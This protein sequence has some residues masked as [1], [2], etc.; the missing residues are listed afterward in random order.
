MPRFTICD[1]ST[2]SADHHSHRCPISLCII[3]KQISSGVRSEYEHSKCLTHNWS[4]YQDQSAQLALLKL[5]KLMSPID[6][7]PGVCGILT[8]TSIHRRDISQVEQ[9]GSYR[10]LETQ[11]SFHSDQSLI[12]ILPGQLVFQSTIIQHR[13]NA[14]AKLYSPAQGS[15]IPLE[16]SDPLLLHP[17]SGLLRL[18]LPGKEH[19][20][21]R[22]VG[23]RDTT[24]C[25]HRQRA[26]SKHQRH[27]SRSVA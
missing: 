10:P 9:K 16:G 6:G 21:T 11:D 23:N 22:L 25:P 7:P 1:E 26:A 12:Y 3:N 8:A 24:L 2:F 27:F 15:W 20:P 18:S 5:V 14:I 17:C 4:T 13:H 19:S